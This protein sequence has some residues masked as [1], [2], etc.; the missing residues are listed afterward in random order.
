MITLK[1]GNYKTGEALKAYGNDDV[2]NQSKPDEK[3][4]VEVKFNANGGKKDIE[5]SIFITGGSF[6]LPA[7]FAPEFY[8]LNKEFAGWQV[9]NETKKAGDII[10]VTSN[11]TVKAIWKDKS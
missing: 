8:P 5:S 3:T 10:K 2:N 9:G 6:V 7:I 1:K 11:T 4:P